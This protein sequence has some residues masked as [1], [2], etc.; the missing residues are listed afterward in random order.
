[1]TDIFIKF[2]L[3][4]DLKDRL[5]R[6]KGVVLGPRSIGL[7]AMIPLALTAFVVLYP[8]NRKDRSESEEF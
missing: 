4:P 3:F 7:V 8:E 2:T 1:M 5:G 6:T